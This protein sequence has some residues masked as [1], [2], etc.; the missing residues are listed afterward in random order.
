MI[1]VDVLREYFELD[2]EAGKIFWKKK[3][4]ARSNRIKLG[5]EAGSLSDGYVRVSLFK[6][7]MMGHKVIW[8]LVNDEWPE[9]DI[10]HINMNRSDNR[11]SNLRKVTRSENFF[12]ITKRS[13]NTSGYK[14]VTTRDQNGKIR[15]V[16]QIAYNHNYKY[17]GIYNSP[18]E[19]KAAYDEAAKLYHGEYARA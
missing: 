17:L 14:G 11:I 16:A 7:K 9:G 4:A 10:D 15:Y 12:N 6:K 2:A 19:A 1:S 18:E 5:N 8:A 3:T 13:T